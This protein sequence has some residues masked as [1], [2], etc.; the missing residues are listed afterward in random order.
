MKAEYERLKREIAYHSHKYYVL[1]APEI[2]DSEYDQMMR[3]LLEIE[4]INPEW[5]T[6][7]SPSQKV[8]GTILSGF[9]EV[10]HQVKMESLQDAFSED[11]LKEFDKRVKS[12]IPEGVSYCVEHKIDGLSVSL[13]YRNSVFERG[14]TR[15]DGTVGE[16]VTE[17]L[18][19]IMS[20][21]LKLNV[22][23]EY[24]EVRGEVFISKKNFEKINTQREEDGKTP[25]ANPRN[26]A[27]G[28]LRQLNSAVAAKRGLDIFVF[29]IQ[30]IEGVEINSHIEAMRFLRDAG[31]K[32]IMND[33]SFDNIDDAIKRVKEIGEERQSLPFDI[34]GAVIKVNN[35]G[36]RQ[37][38]GSTAKTP[39]WAIAYKYPAEKKQTVIREITVQ[40]GRT[41]V[42]TPN[43]RFDTVSLAGTF[44]SRAT[45]HN[46]D[47]IRE[48]DIKIG[49]T[50]TVFKAGDIIPEVLCVDFD[51]RCGDEIEFVMP[52]LCPVCSSPVTRDEG[53]AAYRC[54]GADCPAQLERSITHFVS[55]DAMDIEGMGPAIVSQLLEKGYIKS[56]ADLYYLSK[57]IISSMD[58]MGD[59]SADNL[60]ASIEKSKSNDLPRFIFALGIRHIGLGS[61]KLICRKLKNIDAFFDVD[62]ETLT[63]VDDIG[64]TMAKSV[65]DYFANP[66]VREMIERLKDAGVNM[67]YL[68]EQSSGTKLEGM[69]FVLT[70]TLPTLG[71]KE[72][73][74]IIEENGG[75]VTGSV[76][77][78]TT[79][80]LAGEEAGSKLEKAKAL[81]IP[82]IDEEEFL[83]MINKKD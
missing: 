49:D 25:F 50:V 75:K 72:A 68:Q 83:N 47:Y 79:M 32:V 76:S 67:E 64:E 61:A 51:K 70:G 35:L 9:E 33:I 27:A 60:L 13:E 52:A 3:K 71:R 16:D 73:S 53:E 29:N 78:K 81:G 15:G 18:K 10:V 82:V 66:R 37:T 5:V 20:I 62:S 4:K 30:Q 45:L 31:F 55:R 48:R 12:V 39:R 56:F 63:S 58:K 21:P 69:T 46:M 1:D 74:A 44:V 22:D 65:I 59:K 24:L 6:S 54:T 57:D 7:D 43:A 2:T 41:G 26:M 8:G 14:S 23:V 34:D 40:V 77:K 38:L 17:N 28:S 19:T 42:L 80:V 11:E 36:Q